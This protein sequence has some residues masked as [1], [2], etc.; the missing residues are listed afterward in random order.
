MGWIWLGMDHHLAGHVFLYLPTN[1]YFHTPFSLVHLP[2][3]LRNGIVGPRFPSSSHIRVS[4]AKQSKGLF[5]ARRP[6][7]PGS[8]N[9]DRDSNKG[10]PGWRRDSEPGLSSIPT[11]WIVWNLGTATSALA[12]DPQ[13]LSAGPMPC[14][15][16]PVAACHGSSG[17]LLLAR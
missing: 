3:S 5:R 12:E 14:R 4:A 15:S 6:L 11:L 8:Q 1:P 13:L 16:R 17:P 2:G 9:L 10:R 7:V